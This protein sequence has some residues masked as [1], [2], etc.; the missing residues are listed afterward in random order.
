MMV[1]NNNNYNNNNNNNETLIWRGSW[2]KVLFT[3][4]FIISRYKNTIWDFN[5]FIYLNDIY[6]YNSSNPADS[7]MLAA[8]LCKC[9]KLKRLFR[10]LEA[11][12][13][14]AAVQ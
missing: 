3:Q 14:M 9:L 2:L 10:K 5:L 7:H 12:I 4:Q 1:N 6:R 13:R 8:M 11:L